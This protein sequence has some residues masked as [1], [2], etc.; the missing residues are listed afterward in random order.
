M[1]FSQS[2]LTALFSLLLPPLVGGAATNTTRTV[3]TPGNSHS[4]A[5]SYQFNPRD[6]WQSVIVTNLRYKYRRSF[7][8]FAGSVTT[9]GKNSSSALKRPPS[10]NPRHTSPK[11]VLRSVGESITEFAKGLFGVGKAEPVI[12]TWYAA[13]FFS[14]AMYMELVSDMP[15]YTGHDLLNPSCWTDPTWSP[16]VRYTLALFG[17]IPDSQTYLKG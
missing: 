9:P 8:P 10:T 14:P 6:G 16:T 4:L 17:L 2:V 12:I 15:R 11:S 3:V 7:T 13:F 5:E 1:H